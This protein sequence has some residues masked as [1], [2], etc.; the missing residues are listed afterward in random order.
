MTPRPAIFISAVSRELKSARQLV[1][2][3]LQFLGYE[4]VWQDIFGT[5]QGDLRAM[6]RQKID[7]CKGVVQ[8]AGKCY[9]AEPPAPDEQFGR[10][11]YTQYEAL[12]AR[13]RGKKVWHLFLDDDFPGDPH[14]AE[15]E[16]LRELQATYRR[17]LK[18]ESQLYHPLGS[19]EALE[20]SVLKLRDDLTRLRRGVKQWAAAVIVLLV[21]I[22]GVVVWLQ[23]GQLQANRELVAVKEEI[24]KLREGVTRYADVQ[25]KVRQGQPGQTIAEVQQSTYAELAKQ[26]GVDPK[27]LQ[28][29]LPEYAA[30]LKRSPDA[31]TYERANA[32][33][34][35][36]DYVEAE[37]LA[38]AAAAAAQKATPPKTSDVIDAFELAGFSADARIEYAAALRHFRDAEQLTDRSR[39]P[40][41]WVREQW[42]IAS[43]LVEQ[44]KYAD[45]EQ[46]YRDALGELRRT[47][48]EEN[49]VVL[50][51]R[52]RLASVLLEQ[53]K[54]TE[55]EAE[56]R[57]VI[58][59]Q[60]KALGPEHPDTFGSRNTLA[61]TFKDEGKYAEAETEHR[62]VI[63][64][65]EKVLGPENNTTLASRHNL[66][67]VLLERGEY[68]EAEREFRAVVKLR[69]K[70]IG[71]EH[72]STLI[73][74]DGFAEALLGQGK[75]AEAETELRA[76]IKLQ[77]K[78][79]GP[80]HR[81]TLYSRNDLAN[82]LLKQGRCA[83]AEAE[84]RDVIKL[85]EKVLG[86]EHPDTLQTCYNLAICLKTENKMGEAIVFARRGADG[87]HKIFGPDHPSAL[88][89]AK[90]WQE[91][92]TTNP[93]SR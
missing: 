62:D 90:L 2:N 44:C 17:R 54:C 70:V 64:L 53:G 84:F 65:E 22:V 48:G 43:V 89:Y 6:L 56:L 20:T 1:A 66:A 92:Q 3:T 16:E 47:L 79:L 72:P 60:E 52:N 57:D 36:K 18:T 59:L 76:V 26:L 12:Y 30:E 28:E 63:K 33:Y 13:A 9:G 42:C 41:G 74:R 85:Q 77:E 45:A 38:L 25:I 21:T 80:E 58:R 83:E 69:E 5:E 35:T 93:P 71:P 31:T 32:A 87:T 55:A 39:D 67:N 75:R 50:M 8:L 27:L 10:V 68:P 40:T 78:V 61:N 24:A 91:L 29:K 14:E 19:R 7:G 23:H 11:S 82:V 4:P 46:V 51:L 34:V 49:R 73:S 81:H 88:K 37:R 15:P 86:P